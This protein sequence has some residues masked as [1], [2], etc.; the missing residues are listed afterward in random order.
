MHNLNNHSIATRGRL[1]T[2][3]LL[4]PVRSQTLDPNLI[5]TT[6]ACNSLALRLLFYN[7]TR[8][9]RTHKHTR[10]HTHTH[11][12]THTHKHM[13][14]SSS[15]GSEPHTLAQASSSGGS[16]PHTHTDTGFKLLRE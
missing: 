10:A 5:T 11:T 4:G 1:T 3:L 6:T 7:V 12:H 9:R 16:G 2:P 13:R 15:S 8:H 14:A